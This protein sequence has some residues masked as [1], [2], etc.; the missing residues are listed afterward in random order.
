LIF[1][2]QFHGQ[3][4]LDIFYLLV[5]ILVVLQILNIRK[6]W[7]RKRAW[8]EFRWNLLLQDQFGIKFYLKDENGKWV[9]YKFKT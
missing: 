9:R 3:I 7:F 6:S 2:N 4:H 1:V 5:Q 8:T